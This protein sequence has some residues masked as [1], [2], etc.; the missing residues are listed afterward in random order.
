MSKGSRKYSH[1]L[2][3]SLLALLKPHVKIPQHEK[4]ELTSHRQPKLRILESFANR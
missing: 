3:V 1:H 2:N 4:F